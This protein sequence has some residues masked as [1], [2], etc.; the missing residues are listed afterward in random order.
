L[1]NKLEK[2]SV[3][4]EK[5][6]EPFFYKKTFNSRAGLHLSLI[7]PGN[8]DECISVGRIIL[9]CFQTF[10]LGDV[11]YL[12][13]LIPNTRSSANVTYYVS[14]SSYAGVFAQM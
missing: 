3:L 4:L 6:T 12:W 11:L 9:F 2:T 1:R 10:N 14:C 5:K 8:I 13:R 7:P